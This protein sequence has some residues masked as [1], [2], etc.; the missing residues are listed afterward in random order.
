MPSELNKSSI[1]NGLAAAAHTHAFVQATVGSKLDLIISMLEQSSGQTKVLS[2]T[3]GNTEST[4]KIGISTSPV[5]SSTNR[6]QIKQLVGMSALTGELLTPIQH[7]YQSI[8]DIIFTPLG[9]RVMR[10]TYG[11]RLFDLI[12]ENLTQRTLMRIYAAIA[13]ALQKWEPRFILKRVQLYS[14]D[15]KS[16][17]TLQL[18]GDIR[19]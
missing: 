5:G 4:Q 11:S 9:S 7:L 12:D 1:Q 8:E 17:L 3:N 6:L 13:D 14:T 15:Q 16:K 10:R 18:Y 2:G 19:L